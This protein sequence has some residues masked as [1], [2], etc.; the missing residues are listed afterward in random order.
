MDFCLGFF[1]FALVS[2]VFVE[3]ETTVNTFFELADSDV[4]GFIAMIRNNAKRI[5]NSRIFNFFISLKAIG[6]ICTE[7]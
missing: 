6:Y 5:H 7:Q 1:S 3:M 4:W 2:Y